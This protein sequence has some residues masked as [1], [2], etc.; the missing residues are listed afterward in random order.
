LDEEGEDG[1]STHVDDDFVT[2]D[3]RVGFVV[4]D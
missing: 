3:L 2:H 4:K 1:D